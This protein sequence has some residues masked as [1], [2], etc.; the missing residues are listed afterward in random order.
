M[1]ACAWS[2]ADASSGGASEVLDRL[3]L[4][5]NSRESGGELPDLEKNV[6]PA[7]VLAS[8][9]P[10][11][12]AASLPACESI[13]MLTISFIFSSPKI[14]TP[15]PIPRTAKPAEYLSACWADRARPPMPCRGR[16]ARDFSLLCETRS[17]FS[18]GDDAPDLVRTQADVNAIDRAINALNTSYFSFHHKSKIC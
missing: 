11:S 3:V 4:L 9:C 6:S 15:P 1:L 13:G 5:R 17:N 16:L 7:N 8:V 14:K 10:D 12:E 18:F 2:M